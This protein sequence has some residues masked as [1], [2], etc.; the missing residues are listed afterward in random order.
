MSEANFILFDGADRVNFLPLTFTRPMADLRIG[1][2]TIREKWEKHLRSATSTLTE[3]Y[4]QS[5]HPL[6]V[7]DSSIWINSQC[8]P[9]SKLVTA[10]LSLKTNQTLLWNG[11]VVAYHSS[12]Q[13]IPK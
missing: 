10:I 13:A 4:L 6:T 9:N 7:T 12:D 11:V 5:K 1:I 2:L 8:L 3:Q